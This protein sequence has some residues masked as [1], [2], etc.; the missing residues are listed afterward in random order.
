MTRTL[1]AA[2][3]ATL[4]APV[5]WCAGSI[6]IYSDGFGL[7]SEERELPLKKGR[8]EWLFDG[9]SQQIE[10]ATVLF[11][12]EGVRL[13]EQ[14]YE[15]DLVDEGTLLRRYLGQEI[16]AQLEGGEWLRGT[17]LAGG[18][19]LILQTAQGVTSL[20]PEALV[21]VRYPSLPEGLRLRPALRWELEAQNAG[22]RKATISYLS[23]GLGWKAEYVCLLAEDDNSMEMASWVNLGNQTGLTWEDATLQLV[24]GKVNRVRPA[25][26]NWAK[27]PR[28][29]M[30]EMADA[31][32]GFAEE[33]FF[34]YHLY[35]L[36]RPVTIRDRQD[37]QVS[38]FDP[39]RVTLAKRYITDSNR[40]NEVQ[41]ELEF[42]NSK[43]KGPGLPLPEG[44]VRLYKLD[45]RGRR[46][47]V[48]EDAVKHTPVDERVKLSAGKAFDLVAERKVLDEKRSGRSVD[49]EIEV[50]LRNRKAK[51]SAT[52]IVRERMWGD[53]SVLSSDVAWEKKDAGTLE[54]Q[55]PVKAGETRTVRFRVRHNA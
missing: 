12:C 23:G 25:M 42:V 24:A 45:N 44:T 1:T 22:N 50:V 9:V 2:L 14:N 13:L 52:I 55:V 35:T 6:T 7:I 49:R 27:A 47:M 3:L 37:K 39:K 33:A 48:G 20:R 38:L 18:M 36:E 28:M 54:M 26:E 10:P 5:A 8:Q 34:E 41:V 40:G 19:G 29:A 53:W 43:D 30:A 16:E 11:S 31:A 15:Y 21:A 4:M 32:G 46:Q 51:E 17:L